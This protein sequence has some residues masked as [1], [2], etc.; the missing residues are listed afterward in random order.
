MLV[1]SL[2]LN[3]NSG[4]FRWSRE[5][6]RI[7][8]D[9]SGSTPIQHNAELPSA[10]LTTSPVDWVTPPVPGEVITSEATGNTYTM[11]EKIGEGYFGMVF[12]CVDVW[13][14][15]LAAKVMK[16]MGPYERVK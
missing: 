10:E 8:M 15:D 3:S 7:S 9:D 14:N 1:A 12:G 6:V 13:K 4:L 5:G 11:G 16:P 2:K